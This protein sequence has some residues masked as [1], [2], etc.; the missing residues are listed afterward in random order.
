MEYRD[1]L[2]RSA[3]PKGGVINLAHEA[4][5]GLGPLTIEPALR[6]VRH[7]NG[8]EEVLQPRIMQVLVALIR[9]NGQIL[10]RDALTASCWEGVVVGEDAINRVIG[11]LRR[12]SEG[13]GRG[14]F[15]VETITKVGYRLI[16]ASPTT[17]V[18]TEPIEP[19]LAVLA[20]DNLSGD[21]DIAYFSDGV[22]EEILQT[23]ARGAELKVIGRGSS[24]QFRGAD[25]AAAHVAAT[26][27]ATHVLDG[28]VRRS[29]TMVRIAAH[30][31]ECAGETTLWSDRF[32]RDLS[33]IFFVQDEIAAAV[34][35]ALK[36]AFTPGAKVG[37][38]NPVAYELYLKA[39]ETSDTVIAPETRVA[40]TRLLEQA[41]ALAPRFAGAWARL[42]SVRVAALRYDEQ[43]LPYAVMRDRVVEAAQTALEIDPTLGDIYQTLAELEPFG[44]YRK[45]QEYHNRAISVAPN[46]PRVLYRTGLF[47]SNVG[48]IGEASAYFKKAHALDPAHIRSACLYACMLD[49]QGH[50]AESRALWVR[51]CA[52]WPNAEFILSNAI[53]AAALNAD[54]DRFDELV[55]VAREGDVYTERMRQQIWFGSNLRAPD[56]ASINAVVSQAREEFTRRGVVPTEWLTSL[57]RL[58]QIEPV[59]DLIERASF[60][61][62]FDPEQRWPSESANSTIFLITQN[63]MMNDPRFPRLCSKLGLCDY[64]LQTDRWPDCA[65]DG[66]LPYDFKSEC[67]RMAA[68]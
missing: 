53:N 52:Q 40:I 65:D 51:F 45:I 25:K 50:Y 43:G 23:V 36:I 6:L 21:P 32:D 49:A 66:V 62:M 10:T 33:D 48:R 20:F 64:W 55:E 63:G 61:F 16:S 44:G 42:A 26:L 13:I 37:A 3:T 60:A 18:P 2:G 9:A 54:W 46:D 17:E 35:A 11:Q 15:R 30:L 12:L 28:S 31:I 34:A 56:P 41:V 5:I 39:R 27:K 57:Y 7:D 14:C 1:E 68:T 8:A 67:R 19:V 4:S 29:G 24:F 47:V 22:S 58:G 59:F 38:I